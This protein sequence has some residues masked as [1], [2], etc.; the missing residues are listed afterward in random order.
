MN[1]DQFVTKVK[2]IA[3]TRQML[4][5]RGVGEAADSIIAEY[6]V[7]PRANPS[8]MG[9]KVSALFTDLFTRYDLTKFRVYRTSF[10]DEPQV[11][12][13]RVYFG[14]QEGGRLFVDLLTEE[15]HEI[16]FEDVVNKFIFAKSFDHFM[17]A[18]LVTAE[19]AGKFGPSSPELIRAEWAARAVRAAGGMRYA[20]HWCYDIHAPCLEVV[21][22]MLTA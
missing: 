1:A 17:E 22:S 5:D 11:E 15:V 10:V 19:Y 20:H 8:I 12:Q 21:Q 13:G 3:P 18:L 9:Y 16:S 6:A 7:V 14:W 2:E 4:I